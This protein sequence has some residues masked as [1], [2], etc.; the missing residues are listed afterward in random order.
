MKQ[1]ERNR[2]IKQ[3]RA[4]T[5]RKLD[6]ELGYSED[7]QHKDMVDFYRGHIAKLTEMLTA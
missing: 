4:E 3:A 6:K 2:R 7:L 1:E 5:Q